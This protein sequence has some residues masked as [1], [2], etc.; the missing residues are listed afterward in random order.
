LYAL[1]ETQLFLMD[2]RFKKEAVESK[3]NQINS[4]KLR[5]FGT[6]KK[7]TKLGHGKTG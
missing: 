5:F 3:I 1:P 4:S 6:L 7:R 2:K